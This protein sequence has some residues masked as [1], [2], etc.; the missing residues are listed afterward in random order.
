MDRTR[1]SLRLPPALVFIVLNILDAALQGRKKDDLWRF[2]KTGFRQWCRKTARFLRVAAVSEPPPE[3]TFS[4][5]NAMPESAR[6]GFLK[7]QV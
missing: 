2:K 6:D 4:K 5:A 1:S 7:S 3:P